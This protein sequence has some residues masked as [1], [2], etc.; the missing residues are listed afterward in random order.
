[1][2]KYE[3][4]N[5]AY[6]TPWIWLFELW[7][8]PSFP[9]VWLLHWRLLKGHLPVMFSWNVSFFLFVLFKLPCFVH[10]QF[11]TNN[12]KCFSH[13]VSDHCLNIG[14]FTVTLKVRSYILCLFTSL[15]Q[16]SALGAQQMFAEWTLNVATIC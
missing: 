15:A 2:I 14:S 8:L 13:F 4:L 6:F 7:L 16:S 5:R 1:M 10:P 11:I 3:P 12:S 9:E